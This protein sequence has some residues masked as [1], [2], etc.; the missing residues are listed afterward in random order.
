MDKN[1]FVLG[2]NLQ[3]GEKL[4]SYPFDTARPLQETPDHAI[5]RW[6]A[7]SYASAH[8]TMSETF[9]GGCHTQDMTNAMGI[10]QGAKWHPRAGSMNDFSYLHTNCLELSIYLG[11]DKFPHESELQQEWENNKESL[12]T[13]MEQVHRGI[14]GLVTDQ[15]GEPIANATIVVGGINH[16]IRTGRPAVGITA[17]RPAAS[18]T[19]LGPPNA[20]SCCR[21]PTGSASGRSW[22]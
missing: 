12:L 16:N 2:A 11:C 3:G 10:V 17:S 18:S 19:T 21:A 15:Q 8:L 5:F 14:K 20:T 1:P 13:F 9:R 4:V 6:L 7:I 22:P